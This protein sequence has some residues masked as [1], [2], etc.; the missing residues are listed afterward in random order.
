MRGESMEASTWS[1]MFDPFLWEAFWDFM[2]SYSYFSSMQWWVRILSQFLP[3]TLV[4]R[5]ELPSS[6][7]MMDASTSLCLSYGC[8]L[9]SFDIS[10][11]YLFLTICSVLVFSSFL[12]T[13]DHFLP[14]ALTV[15]RRVRSS[16]CVHSECNLTGSRW[17][18]QCSRHCFE[19]L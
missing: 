18:I 6:L 2:G 3:S 4:A 19:F 8:L 15:E 11:L 13:N 10:D 5:F 16:W 7:A 1:L 9:S 12:T 17:F 14:W